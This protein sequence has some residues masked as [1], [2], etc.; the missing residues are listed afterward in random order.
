MPYNTSSNKI[1]KNYRRVN[2]NEVDINKLDKSSLNVTTINYRHNVFTYE[3]E[4]TD[5]RDASASSAAFTSY[6]E[7]KDFPS[8]YLPFISVQ[9]VLKTVENDEEEPNQTY[10]N[11]TDSMGWIYNYTIK[12]NPFSEDSEDNT[13]HYLISQIRLTN[14]LTYPF[15]YKE[16]ITINYPKADEVRNNTQ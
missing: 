12:K 13:V 8:S 11:Q 6:L 4:W 3:T 16:I 5:W 15:D 7:L 9:L 2:Q 14:L 10:L 1:R